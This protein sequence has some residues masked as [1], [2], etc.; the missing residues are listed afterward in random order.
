MLTLVDSCHILNVYKIV[1][2]HFTYKCIS[3]NISMNFS[4]V[5][6]LGNVQYEW[7]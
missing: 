5:L 1:I 3:L 7:K 6:N 2:I 4:T